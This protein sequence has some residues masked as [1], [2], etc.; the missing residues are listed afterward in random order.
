[1]LEYD[2]QRKTTICGTPNY[3]APEVLGGSS[4]GHSY[5]VDIWSIGVMI[6]ALMI[7]KPPFETSDVKSTYKRIKANAYTF[8]EDCRLSSEARGLITSILRPEPHLRPT[9]EDII[10]HPFLTRFRY[11]C[12]HV[13][14][15]ICVRCL[16][17]AECMCV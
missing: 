14:T 16:H 9:L 15:H 17:V 7:G 5:E 11:A 6:Y 10:A 4:V 1:M 13:H 8:P 12:I 3:I 2:G